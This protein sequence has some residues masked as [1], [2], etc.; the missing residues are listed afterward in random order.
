MEMTLTPA[1][2]RAARRDLGPEEHLRIAFAGGC[3]AMGFRLGATRRVA[4]GDLRLE[5]DGVAVV[6]DRMAVRELDGAVLDHDEEGGFALDH[7]SWG[8]SC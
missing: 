1:A 6:L 8:R 2:R 5:I 7:P 4:E 3:G